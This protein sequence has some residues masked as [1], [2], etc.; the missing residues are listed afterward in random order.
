MH[1]SFTCGCTS[2]G[3]T[4]YPV[5][6]R[7]TAAPY[8][9]AA[10]QVSLPR[11]AV[12]VPVPER[13]AAICRRTD[14]I[15]RR[16]PT[17]LDE[18]L[19]GLAYLTAIFDTV[20]RYARAVDAQLLALGQERLPLDHSFLRFGSWM[21]GDRDGNP[22]VKPHTTRDV[23]ISSR[24]AACD[25]Y[26]KLV[27]VRA[28]ACHRLPPLALW[29]LIEHCVVTRT[30]ARQ[31]TRVGRCRAE[32]DVGVVGVALLAGAEAGVRQD[33]DRGEAARL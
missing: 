21:G 28:L 17:P 19:S 3:C 22:N 15:R 32:A 7:V 23:V 24:L 8:A 5:Q 25:L 26:M 10:T 29:L 30:A 11:V 20:P 33:L 13:C 12:P 16:K 31:V 4:A 27:G 6:R 2:P 9:C 18:M 1:T 14:E